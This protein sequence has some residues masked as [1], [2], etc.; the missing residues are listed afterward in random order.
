V[1]APGLADRIRRELFD[2]NRQEW[3]RASGLSLVFFLVTA[4]YWIVKPIKRG[5]M[6]SMYTDAPLRIGGWELQAPEVEQMAKVSD[7]V[8]AIFLVAVFTQLVRRFDRRRLVLIVC[9]GLSLPFAAFAF[10]VDTPSPWVAWPLF[11]MGDMYATLMIGTFW[12]ITNDLM[13]NG[14]AERAYGIIGLGGV[15]GGFVGASTVNGLVEAVGRAP[16]LFMASATILVIGGMTLV[17]ERTAGR[18]RGSGIHRLVPDDRGSAWFEGARLVRRSR[19]LMAIV[20][21]VAL[22]ETVS[23]IIDFQLSAAVQ[24]HVHGDEEK[25]AFFG[26]VGQLN[27]VVSILAQLLVT[28]WVM[29]RFGVGAALLVLPAAVFCGSLGFLIVPSLALAAVMSCS[30]NALAYSV[31]QSAK[32]ALYVPLG[33]QEKYKA[34]AFIDMF[35]QRGAK[36]LSI[37]IALV[38]AELVG[39]DGARWL[40]VLTLATL[41]GWFWIARWVGKRNAELVANHSSS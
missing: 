20:G 16:L 11:I 28:S 29:R 22:Y 4:V 33:R 40:S 6:L 3:A 25:D 38:A 23:N 15:V 31:N 12:A 41:A 18:G 24:L 13:R 26:M 9:V 5:L 10:V 7:M 36:V 37:A 39:I 14:E 30:D 2:L 27:G 17:V 19:Y 35:V 32:E 8:A 21:L 1:N 34:K